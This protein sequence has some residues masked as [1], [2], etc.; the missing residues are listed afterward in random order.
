MSS[1]GVREISTSDTRAVKNFVA[2]ERKLVGSN[3]LFV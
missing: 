3:P 1:E 2:L